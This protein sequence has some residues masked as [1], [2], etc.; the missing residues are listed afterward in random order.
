M[1]R[2]TTITLLATLLLAGCSTKSGET[3]A[4]PKPSATSPSASPTYDEYDCRA[5][6]ERNYEQD[7][8]HDA[9]GEPECSSLTHDEYLDVVKKVLAGRKDE[10]LEDAEQHVTWDEAWKGTDAEQQDVVCDRL[11]EDGPEVVGVE[12]AESSGDDEAEQV[13]M[14]QYLLDEKC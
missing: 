10:I 2:A 13:E 12:M 6:L 14:A 4:D 7:N 1:R 11:R 9:S 5:V 3:K 8:I